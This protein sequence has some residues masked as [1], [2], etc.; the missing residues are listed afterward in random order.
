MRERFRVWYTV[1][2]R[3][4]DM[5]SF[6]HVNNAKYFTYYESARIRYF[7]E[8]GML[9]HYE[10]RRQAPAMVTTTCNFRRQARYP[11]TLEVGIRIV[12]IGKSSFTHEYCIFL[13]DQ[14]T[15]VADGTSVCAWI[16]YD[17]NQSIMLPESLRARMHEIDPDI[18]AAPPP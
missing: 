5:D 16:D 7:Q 18:E 10:S 17:A 6:G 11:E 3:W 14:D 15:V 2:V 13:K 4:G 1:D 12:K 9:D 8:V